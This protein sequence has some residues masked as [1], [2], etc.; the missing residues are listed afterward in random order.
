[1]TSDRGQRVEVEDE[2]PIRLGGVYSQSCPCALH[3]PHCASGCN[4]WEGVKARTAGYLSAKLPSQEDAED[5]M[6]DVFL[7]VLSGL[8]SLKE[9]EALGA[10]TLEIAR[11]YVS[12]FYR[13]RSRQE[14]ALIADLEPDWQEARPVEEVALRN[15]V[16]WEAIRQL[17]LEDRVLLVL[18]CDAGRSMKEVAWWFRWTEEKTKKRC[19]RAFRALRDLMEADSRD[20]G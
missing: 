13:R 3:S 2:S 14:K 5:A 7:R 4:L 16:F 6:G 19:Q 18:H 10:W 11:H 20:D 1:M 8:D 15:C 12:D 17:D 9:P